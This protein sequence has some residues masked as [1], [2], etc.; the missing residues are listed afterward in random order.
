[1]G[2]VNGFGHSIVFLA[3]SSPHSFGNMSIKDRSN[4]E[5][6]C[7]AKSSPS[8]DLPLCILLTQKM[9]EDPTGQAHFFDIID[10]V[11]VSS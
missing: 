5:D 6:L 7:D 11:S 9:G 8:G 4:H 2:L 1:M 3:E 10:L